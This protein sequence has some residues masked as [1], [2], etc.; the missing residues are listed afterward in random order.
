VAIQLQLLYSIETALLQ[1]IE[2]LELETDLFV[3]S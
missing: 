3:L 2:L 1:G